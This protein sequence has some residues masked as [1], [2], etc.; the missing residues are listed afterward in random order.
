M[1]LFP[2]IYGLIRISPIVALAASGALWTWVNIDPSINLTNW[3][4]GNGW[5]FN[6]FA[7]QFLFVIG[8]LGALLLRRYGGNLP[9]P[10]WLRAAAWAYLGFAL[11][12]AAP[13]EAWGW[14]NFHPIGLDMPDK[15][16]LAPLR[17][18]DV[19]ALAVL[20]LEFRPVPRLVGAARAAASWSSA[21]AIRWRCSRWPRSWR[22]SAAWC[23]A[24]SASPWRR[25][26]WPTV[27][28]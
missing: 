26:C 6:P 14:F 28:G 19:L 16:V 10:L 4:D 7:W 3:L 27:S 17:L 25:S 24:R 20:A 12:A 9:R 22:W 15:T 18:L 1:A 2:L 23:S 8:A 5:F 13:W 11:V 21:A